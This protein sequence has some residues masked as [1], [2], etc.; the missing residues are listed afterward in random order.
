M[1]NTENTAR[2]LQITFNGAKSDIF[3]ASKLDWCKTQCRQMR[4]EFGWKV[5]LRWVDAPATEEADRIKADEEYKAR[6]LAQVDHEDDDGS[7]R[8]IA[9]EMGWL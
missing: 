5:S 6:I 9:S 2:N 1:N 3:P 7:A 8:E 4:D